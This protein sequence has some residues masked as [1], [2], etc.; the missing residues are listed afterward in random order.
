[1]AELPKVEKW[2]LPADMLRTPGRSVEESAQENTADH[3]VVNPDELCE[4]LTPLISAA[5]ARRT[6]QRRYTP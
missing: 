5:I 2:T 1:M 4:A 6:R 3:S